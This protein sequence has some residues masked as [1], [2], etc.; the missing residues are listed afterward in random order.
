MKFFL[1]LSFQ[2]LLPSP[3]VWG[4]W[5]EMPQATLTNNLGAGRPPCGGRGL[6]FLQAAEILADKPVAPRVGGVD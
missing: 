1:P 4:A 6:K 3:P 5:I 2:Q